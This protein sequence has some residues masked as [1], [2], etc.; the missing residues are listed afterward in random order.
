MLSRA[1]LYRPRKAEEQTAGRSRQG[2]LPGGSVRDQYHLY[3]RMNGRFM[4]G[5]PCRV[6][7]MPPLPASHPCNSN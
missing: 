1:A 7:S 2:R 3:M 5:P 6:H 4:I